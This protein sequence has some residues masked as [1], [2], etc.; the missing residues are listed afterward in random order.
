[1]NNRETMTK[2]KKLWMSQPWMKMEKTTSKDRENTI[3]K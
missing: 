2:M 1:M 3:N